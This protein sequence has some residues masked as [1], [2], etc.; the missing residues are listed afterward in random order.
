M[1]QGGTILKADQITVMRRPHTAHAVGNVHLIDPELEMWASQADINLET[2]TMEL[3]NAKI[4]AKRNTYHLEGKHIRKVAGQNY[5]VL[6]GF[7]TTCG[8][9]ARNPRLEP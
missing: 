7:F 1:T 8:C 9:R 5:T 6:N 2:E 4:L 3:E